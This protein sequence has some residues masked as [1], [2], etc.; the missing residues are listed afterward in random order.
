MKIAIAC[1][2]PSPASS[3]A[4]RFGRAAWFLV[5]DTTSD[6]F[7]TLPHQMDSPLT[8]DAGID[9]ARMLVRVRVGAVVAGGFGDSATRILHNAHV[10]LM[11]A[12]I[13]TAARALYDFKHGNLVDL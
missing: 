5:F 9:A 11:S 2:R 13:I 8:S 7:T 4:P 10:C 6:R 12:G 3:V 1:A